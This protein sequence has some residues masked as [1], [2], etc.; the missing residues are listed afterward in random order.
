MQEHFPASL[1]FVGVGGIGMSGLAQ[2]ARSL[3]HEVSGSDRA[4]DS[5]ENAE[6]FDALRVQG[7]RLYPQDGSRFKESALPDALVYSTAIESGNPDFRGAGSGVLRLH[8]SEAMAEAIRELDSGHTIAVTGTCGKTSVSAWLAEALDFLGAE[9]GVLTGGLVNAFRSRGSA[10]NYRRGKGQYF[11]LEADESDKSLLNYSSDSGIVLNIG[12]DHYP[13]EELAQVFGK[14]LQ[15]AARLAVV[16]EEAYQT[17]LTHSGPLPEALPKV[18]F[19]MKAEGPD[20]LDGLRVFRLEKYESGRDGPF[21]VI[22]DAPRRLRLPGPGFHNAANALALYAE[23]VTLGFQAPAVLNAL[24]S[25]HGVWRRFD[26]A[27]KNRRGALFFDDYAHNVEKI[28]SCIRAGRELSSGRIIA[29][30]QPH[31]YGPLGFMR[32]DLFRALEEVLGREDVFALLPV[33]YAGGT[34]SFKPSSFEVVREYRETGRHRYLAPLNRDEAA[35]FV[36]DNAREGDVVLVM[37][38]RDNSLSQWTRFLAENT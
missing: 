20:T 3:G 19:S 25:F 36:R 15:S 11:V 35:A 17:I 8:R 13:R 28:V 24:E 31:G 14:F 5:P 16:E 38:A 22:K 27:G 7:I 32:S 37:G 21:A 10:G 34:S 26:P 18:L 30:F 23:L 4:V 12:T 33:Y 2:M 9:P 6:I 1:H 29:L